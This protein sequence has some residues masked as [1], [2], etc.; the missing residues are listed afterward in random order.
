MNQVLEADKSLS[1]DAVKI[2]IDTLLERLRQVNELELNALAEC[3]TAAFTY[4]GSK[5]PD[6]SIALLV[7]V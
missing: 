7:A 2:V 1:S 4:Q 5:L 3:L 6:S